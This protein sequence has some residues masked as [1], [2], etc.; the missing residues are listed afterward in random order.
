MW[1]TIIT[2]A[3]PAWAFITPF[4]FH[5]SINCCGRALKLAAWWV[6]GPT[7]T[8]FVIK[9]T[10]AT[11]G[12]APRANTKGTK[13]PAVITEYA[14]KI[15]PII[16]L[17]RTIK[18]TY[19]YTPIKRL[20]RNNTPLKMRD[21]ITP[22]PATVK[23]APKAPNNWDNTTC[24]NLLSHSIIFWYN[25]LLGWLLVITRTEIS[26]YKAA[27][28]RN[29]LLNWNYFCANQFVCCAM[30][31]TNK[32]FIFFNL[33]DNIGFHFSS[34]DGKSDIDTRLNNV[35]SDN[36]YIYIPILIFGI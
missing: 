3:T 7:I 6:I 5:I 20:W 27:R 25:R 4:I 36:S 24:W 31:I 11:I 29:L 1:I 12:L 8:C 13:T 35:N 18:R 23:I 2:R 14:A 26:K 21:N 19:Q 22:T 9:S 17:N 28:L 10:S 32:N 30:R 34:K 16:I 33:L 15:F